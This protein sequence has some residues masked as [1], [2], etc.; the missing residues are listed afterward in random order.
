MG[1][2]IFPGNGSPPRAWGKAAHLKHSPRLIRFTPT[3]VGKRHLGNALY[4]HLPVHPHVR[5]EKVI[6][7]HSA[8][9]EGGSPPRAWGKAF[10]YCLLYFLRRFTPTC[11]GKRV[12]HGCH[13][14]S[15]AVH[16]HVR[17]EKG[18]VAL[19][20]A[21]PLGS[22]PRAWGKVYIR[23]ATKSG[24]RFT[25]TCVGKS[26]MLS[27]WGYC[28]PVHPHVRGEKFC[29]PLPVENPLGSPPR[30]WGKVQSGEY[31]SGKARF[32]PTCVGKSRARR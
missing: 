23:P 4:E 30:A 20:L 26:T 17:G 15:W 16:P 2:F 22:P 19:V 31:P 6:A 10:L 7:K 14:R 18:N 8:I 32:T 13:T 12:T 11:V 24:A 1:Y 25:P 27:K 3:C 9:P 28:I 5:G 29:A 21:E